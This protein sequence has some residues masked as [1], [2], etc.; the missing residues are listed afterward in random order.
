MRLH[1]LRTLWDRGCAGFEKN[2]VLRRFVVFRRPATLARTA[3]M[4]QVRVYEQ[5]V[6]CLRPSLEH[7]DMGVS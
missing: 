7:S 2:D 3:M 5:F 1:Q 6:E 4:G